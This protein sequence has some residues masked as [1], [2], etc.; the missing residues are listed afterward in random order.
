MRKKEAQIVRQ[1]VYNDPIKRKKSKKEKMNESNKKIHEYLS[2]CIEY[3]L[4]NYMIQLPIV[5]LVLE[6]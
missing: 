5:I 1:C 4:K 6:L 3:K 2:I